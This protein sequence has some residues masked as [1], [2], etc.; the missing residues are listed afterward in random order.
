MYN[1]VSRSYGAP[2]KRPEVQSA[3]IEFIAPSEYMVPVIIVFIN[4][5]I[6][7]TKKNMYSLNALKSLWIK[8]SAKCINVK[9][10]IY[11]FNLYFLFLL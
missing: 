9:C 2:H 1:P 11:S 6:K 10:N 5:V 3:T 4:I 7:K 8:A